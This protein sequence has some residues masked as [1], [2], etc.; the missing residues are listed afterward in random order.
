MDLLKKIWPTCFM[1]KEKDVVSLIVQLVIFLVIV[2]VVGG[3]VSLLADIFII[4]IIFSLLGSLIGIYNLVG[5]VLWIL[6]FLGIVK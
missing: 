6:K 4:G 5:F 1:V 2:A 3:L